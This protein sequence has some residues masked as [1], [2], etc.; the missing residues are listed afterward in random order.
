M[1]LTTQL[2]TMLAMIGMGGWLGVALDTYNRF[3]QR[4]DR[5]HWIVF[6]NDI[7]FW[8]VQSL[9][10]FYVLLL[11][12][13]GELRFYIF[14]AIL[15]GYAAYQSLFRKIYLKVLE[16][17]I[18]FVTRLYQFFVQLCRYVIIR[19]IQLLLQILLAL[20]LFIGKMLLSLF[21]LSLRILHQLARLLFAPFRWM[22]L[23]I[24]KITPPRWQRICTKIF[25]YLTGIIRQMKNM[26]D[27]IR[28]WISKWQK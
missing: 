13:Q 12:N 14:L 11:V 7:L 6:I 2:A 20:I 19:P 18:W 27:R 3:L 1:S 17:L 8:I 15:C 22:A 25:A 16:W 4:Q 10:I 5:S 26:K 28:T 24:W 23:I 9:I 21:R